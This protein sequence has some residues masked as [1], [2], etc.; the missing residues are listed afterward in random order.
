MNLREVSIEQ[1]LEDFPEMAGHKVV[2]LVGD[3]VTM[4]EDAA[5]LCEG[6]LGYAC[7]QGLCEQA[8]PLVD[9]AHQE[10]WEQSMV[11]TADRLRVLSADGTEPPPWAWEL[12]QGF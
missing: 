6:R 3:A 1:V 7:V 12:L 5:T 11:D 4:L 10:A 8:L 9:A 2:E